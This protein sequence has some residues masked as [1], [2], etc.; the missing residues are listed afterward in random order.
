MHTNY[1]QQY[2]WQR[3]EG[4]AVNLENFIGRPNV[5]YEN[6]HVIM[7][8]ATCGIIPTKKLLNMVLFIT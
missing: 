7:L 5:S 4:H 1:A 3:G 8:H 6:A 2:R